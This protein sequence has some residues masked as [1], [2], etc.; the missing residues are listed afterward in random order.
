MIFLQ[1]Q[2]LNFFRLI[3]SGQLAVLKKNPDKEVT[4]SKDDSIKKYYGETLYMRTGYI[5]TF[6]V[7]IRY[8]FT[9]KKT[10]FR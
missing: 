5:S 8:P 7:G 3:I 4:C 1:A 9:V 2:N 10:V 6:P